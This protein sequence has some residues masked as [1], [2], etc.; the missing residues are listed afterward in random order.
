M[1]S[2]P[3]AAQVLLA[4]NALPMAA[5]A[6][7]ALTEAEVH[8]DSVEFKLKCAE[9]CVEQLEELLKPVPIRAV[10]RTGGPN[11][12]LVNLYLDGF[13]TSAVSASDV[14]G[15]EINVY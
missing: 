9:Y 7:V 10:A 4:A 8:S 6:N 15:H 12:F 1:I 13:L 2:L 11:L 3:N 5:G 14:F